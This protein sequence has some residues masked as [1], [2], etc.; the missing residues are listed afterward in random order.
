[1][2]FELFFFLLREHLEPALAERGEFEAVLYGA[3]A[4]YFDIMAN[5]SKST[6][7]NEIKKG[8]EWNPCV[9]HRLN[10][11]VTFRIA[12]R[13]SCVIFDRTA[14]DRHLSTHNTMYE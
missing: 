11:Y 14:H 12:L 8:L 3:P 4:H 9:G 10:T 5:T 1:M 7:P 13:N 2:L 6:H